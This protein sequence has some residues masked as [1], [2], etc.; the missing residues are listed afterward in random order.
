MPKTI[1]INIPDDILEDYQTLDD[2]RR[3]VYEDLIIEERQKGNISMGRAAQLLSI[4]YTEFFD[5]LGSR[6][7]SWINVTKEDREQ[8]YMLFEEFLK[9]YKKP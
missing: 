9:T 1:S 4:T 8:S 3:A 2:V 5:L 7:F 6:G